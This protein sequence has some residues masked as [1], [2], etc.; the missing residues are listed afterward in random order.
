M[1]NQKDVSASQQTDTDRKIT[2][3]TVSIYRK[4]IEERHSGLKGNTAGLEP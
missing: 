4:T 1:N 3:L 2:D